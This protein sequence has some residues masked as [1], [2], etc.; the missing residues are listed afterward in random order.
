MILLMVVC[1]SRKYDVASRC[2]SYLLYQ[3]S[4]IKDKYK[5]RLD[6]FE[7]ACSH[8]A[9]RDGTDDSVIIS[10]ISTVCIK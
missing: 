7:Y 4:E 8:L 6:Q 10:A 5:S 9:D 3:C 2:V 1:M